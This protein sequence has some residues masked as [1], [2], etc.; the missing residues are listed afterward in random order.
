MENNEPEDQPGVVFSFQGAFGPP[1]LGHYTAMKLYAQQVLHDYPGHKILMLFMPTAAGSKVHLQPTQNSRKHLLQAFCNY[2]TGEFV[3]NPITFEPSEI[4][5]ELYRSGEDTA[6]YRTIEE[7]RSRFSKAEIVLGMGLDN[8][9]Q[10]PYWKNVIQYKDNVTKIY[11]ASRKLSP[12]EKSNTR[13]FRNSQ[14]GVIVNFDINVPKWGPITLDQAKQAFQIEGSTAEDL[15]NALREKTI[16]PDVVYHCNLILPEFVMVGEGGEIPGTSSSMMRYYICKYITENNE[17]YKEE[18]KEKVRKLIWGDNPTDEGVRYTIDD[19]KDNYAEIFKEGC[20]ENKEYDA[21][22][23][24]IFPQFLGG[25]K[26]YKKGGKRI[27]SR[28]RK[29]TKK[30]RRNRRYNYSKKG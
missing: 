3:G 26:T 30:R 29:R 24:E 20:P 21:I 1:T 19:Y 25:K 16:N 27:Q 28:K 11:V 8:M 22:F 18:Y 9:L 13:M 17:E 15:T 4:E 23:E 14:G 7:L 2:L 5:Y 12:A 6:T 10:L